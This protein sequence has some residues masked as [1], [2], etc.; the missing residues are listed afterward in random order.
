MGVGAAD[1]AHLER[2]H[3]EAFGFFEPVLEGLAQVL[4]ADLAVL[5]GRRGCSDVARVPVL[6]VREGVVGG[7][8][9]VRLAIAL[10][11]GDLGDRFV[12]RTAKGVVA[13]EGAA[14]A[15]LEGEHLAVAHVGVVRDGE[16]RAAG[17]R[18]V[19]LHEI[20]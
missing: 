3:A 12:P 9:R 5:L 13:V 6:E 1:H 11:L 17:L 20:P 4:V 19:R 16:D 15:L 10:D 8:E 18:F 7:E 14:V 2:V